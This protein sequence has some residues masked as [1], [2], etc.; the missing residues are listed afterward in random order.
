MKPSSIALAM[1]LAAPAVPAAAQYSQP[2][3]PPQ[4]TATMP[5]AEQAAPKS[6]LKISRGAAKAIGELQAAIKAN[7]TANI[8]AKVAAAQAAAKSADDR[9]AIAALQYTVAKAANDSAGK[10]AAIEALIAS[11][12]DA[13]NHELVPLT[14]ELGATYKAANQLDRAASTFERVLASDPT[15]IEA[16][17]N[18]AETR[19]AQGRG[20]DAVSLLQKAIAART[21]SGQKVEESW[22]KRALSIGYKTKSP[23]TL[24]IARSWVAAYPSPASWRDA[25]AI[26]RNMGPDDDQSILDILRLQRAAGA[27]SSDGDYHKY[28]F[29]A[30]SRGYAGEAKLLMEEAFAAKAIDPN[31]QLFRDIMAEATKR[32]AGDRAA[33]T[34]DAKTALAGT[35]AKRALAT[36]DAYFGYKDYAKAAELYRAALTKNGADKD[37]INLHLG[38]ALARAGDKAGA[39][40]ALSAVGGTRADLA[41][42]WLLYVNTHG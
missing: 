10:A 25:L 5:A 15:N 31:K 2:A 24:D 42:Y 9:Y 11:G 40:A 8:P 16:T 34:E 26:Y 41:K 28:G 33:M 32:S 18:L 13:S 23:A 36:G 30:V 19:N 3:P 14:L 39:T 6:E 20:G 1:A 21:A 12:S 22:Y 4:Q 7:D 38:M 37:L 17:V 29:L 35:E 27:M